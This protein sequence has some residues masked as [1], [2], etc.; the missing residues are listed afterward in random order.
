MEMLDQV[1]EKVDRKLYEMSFV[2]VADSDPV[3]FTVRD[4]ADAKK[5]HKITL[6]S[7]LYDY[8]DKAV[9]GKDAEGY[10]HY[11]PARNIINVNEAE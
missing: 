2:D 11:I 10:L 8:N 7:G 5:A 3:T 9:R 1:K 4:A 6:V